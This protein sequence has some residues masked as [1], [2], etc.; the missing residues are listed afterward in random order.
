MKNQAYCFITDYDGTV[1]DTLSLVHPAYEVAVEQVFGSRGIDIYHNELG[2]LQNRAPSEL[3]VDL[4]R[5]GAIPGTRSNDTPDTGW[6]RNMTAMVTEIKL[7]TLFES[8]GT[9]IP[10]SGDIYPAPMPGF[11]NF[12]QLMEELKEDGVDVS[13]GL[14]SSGHNEFLDRATLAWERHYGVTYKPEIQITHDTIDTH[15]YPKEQN[16]RVKP[17]PFPIGLAHHEFLKQTKVSG[18][19]PFNEAAVNSREKMA[20]FGDDLIKD[21]DMAKKAGL[22]FGHIQKEQDVSLDA[23][24]RVITFK[25]WDTIVT[26]LAQKQGQDMLREGRSLDEV[27]FQQGRSIEGGPRQ[28][29]LS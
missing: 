12:L 21:G 25:N 4:Y 23:S 18:K 7:D 6:V 22:V 14:V 11:L 2:G 27:F 1:A 26:L 28:F 9:S 19:I 29:L 8:I 10:N 24:T 16:R 5:F 3:V 17:A 20:Y 13:L 15:H